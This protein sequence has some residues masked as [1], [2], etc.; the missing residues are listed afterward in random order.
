MCQR[1]GAAAVKWRTV[2]P[3]QTHRQSGTLSG[4]LRE[5]PELVFRFWESDQNPRRSGWSPDFRC[6]SS[7]CRR[8]PPLTW[9]PRMS[10]ARQAA[11][12]TACSASPWPCTGSYN[13]RIKQCERWT[14]CCCCCC[15][16]TRQRVPLRCDPHA[17]RVW[18][19]E[20]QVFSG[21]WAKRYLSADTWSL[22]YLLIFTYRKVTYLRGCAESF[23]DCRHCCCKWEF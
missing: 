12:P 10:C 9:T 21:I 19:R 1:G 20:L 6:W 18:E 22:V 8:V 17:R 3:P 7:W 11:T 14:F 13:R 16:M 5:S 15:Y 4:I 2:R 23:S